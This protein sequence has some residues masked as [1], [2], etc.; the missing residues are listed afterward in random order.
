[1]EHQL[2]ESIYDITVTDIDGEQLDIADWE[3][4]VIYFVLTT[5]SGEEVRQLNDLQDIF[6]EFMMRGFFVVAIPTRHFGGEPQDAEE[7]AEI[8]REDHDVSFPILAPTETT[9]DTC[10]SLVRWLTDQATVLAQHSPS[11]A[12]PGPVRQPFEKFIIGDDGRLLARFS[13]HTEPDHDS[14]LELVESHL[15]VQ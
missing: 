2:P 7:I 8:M 13:G 10:S 11:L 9:G 5:T 3:G 14:L 15:P 6:D 12:F 4:H 1:M